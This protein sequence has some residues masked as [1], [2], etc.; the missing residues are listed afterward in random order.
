[1]PLVNEHLI[2]THFEQYYEYVKEDGTIVSQWSQGLVVTVKTNNNNKV[3][4]KWDEKHL[5]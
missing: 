2:G 4:S 5:H 3:T 1:M